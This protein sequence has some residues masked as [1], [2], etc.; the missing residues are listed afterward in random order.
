[1]YSSALGARAAYTDNSLATASPA[2]LL[3]ML[4]DR[5]VLDI[6][7]GL[8]ATEAADWEE[9]RRNLLHAQDI[10]LELE[11]GLDADA[12]TG[13][14]Q[15]A[16]LYAYLRGRLVDANVHRDA[17]AATEARGLAQHLAET[18]RQAALQ[19]AVQ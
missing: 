9:A 7:R 19:A 4:M 1:M 12:M 14:K 15:L 3:V 2:R 10:V 17:T 18:W 8:A 6:E 13:G 11:V 16:A 5:L